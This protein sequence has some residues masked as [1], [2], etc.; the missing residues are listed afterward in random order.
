MGAVADLSQ[1]RHRV[2]WR[3]DRGHRDRQHGAGTGRLVPGQRLSV[4]RRTVR[5]TYKL[6]RLR[7]RSFVP[8]PAVGRQG[9][10]RWSPALPRSCRDRVPRIHLFA[11]RNCAN[12][13]LH[14]IICKERDLDRNAISNSTRVPGVHTESSEAPGRDDSCPCTMHMISTRQLARAMMGGPKCVTFDDI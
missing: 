1:V 13:T 8:V 9:W 10:P 5:L 14:T 4:L 11:M 6:S 12:P 3:H 2:G 7:F